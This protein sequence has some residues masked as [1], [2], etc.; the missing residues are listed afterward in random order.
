MTITRR[1][2]LISA[3]CAAV[4]RPALGASA[5]EAGLK[6]LERASGGRLGVYALDAASGHTLLS[7][8]ED[9]RFAMCST[10]KLPLAAAVLAKVDAG[11]MGLEQKI[12]LRKEDLLSYAPVTAARVSEGEMSVRDLAAGMIELSDNTAAN[13]LLKLVDGPEGLIRWLRSVGDQVTRLDR[14]EPELN[15]NLPDDPRDTT[16]PRAMAETT[17]RLFTGP[18]LRESSRELLSQW[19]VSASTGHKRIRAGLPKQWRV[20]DK[21][22]TGARGAV[23]DVAIA[24]PEGRGPIVIAVYMSESERPTPE[25]EAIHARVAGLLI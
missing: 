13:L 10:F 16:T 18:V 23:N 3:L 6:V 5:V 8:A 1:A 20:G 7:I 22:G 14:T 24:W 15:S 25:L 4:T 12:K 21:T 11:A 19:M 9:E 2:A 17:A